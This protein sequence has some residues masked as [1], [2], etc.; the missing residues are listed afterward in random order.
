[1]KKLLYFFG[2]FLALI[3]AIGSLGYLLW[4]KQY[5]IAFGVAVL[6]DAAYPTV[7]GWVKKL[8]DE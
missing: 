3:G 4:M 2:S 1:M 8:V 5:V 6:I 7:R